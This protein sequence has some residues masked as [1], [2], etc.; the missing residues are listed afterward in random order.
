M[1]LKLHK[2]TVAIG[3][4]LRMCAQ[5]VNLTN[6][7][8]SNLVFRSKPIAEAEMSNRLIW[9]RS[10]LKVQ[11]MWC[12]LNSVWQN[13]DL[14]WEFRFVYNVQF[15]WFVSRDCK[16]L[17]R[18]VSIRWGLNWSSTNQQGPCS[19]MLA[20]IHPVVP[21]LSTTVS[22]TPALQYCRPIGIEVDLVQK[23][24]LLLRLSRVRSPHAFNNLV[25]F[26]AQIHLQ[27]T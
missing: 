7:G 11:L 10:T 21:M 12:L 2:P 9:C 26:S 6:P 13:D 25:G 16:H 5:N 27:F 1:Q 24:Y 17:V 8:R 14:L 22:W 19:S 4:S 20:L 3:Y 18:M 23:G 15:R